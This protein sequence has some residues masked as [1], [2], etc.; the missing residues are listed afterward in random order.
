MNELETTDSIHDL[1]VLAWLQGIHAA[2]MGRPKAANPYDR[3]TRPYLRRVWLAGH[4]DQTRAE[5]RGLFS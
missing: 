1:R 5:R 4:R 3:R 2:K